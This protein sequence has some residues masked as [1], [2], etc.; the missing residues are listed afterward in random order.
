[1]P[2][3]PKMMT[4]V[5]IDFRLAEKLATNT[6]YCKTNVLGIFLFLK[7]FIFQSNIYCFFKVFQHVF[8]ETVFSGSQSR[9]AMQRSVWAPF[10]IFQGSHKHPWNNF[11]V[12]EVAK[13]GWRSLRITT[14]GGHD[15]IGNGMCAKINQ[16]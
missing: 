10:A 9:S 16:K 8:L 4:T 2:L 3:V 6:F 1:M 13:R 12:Q 7:T 15:H 5:N 14:F 11:G